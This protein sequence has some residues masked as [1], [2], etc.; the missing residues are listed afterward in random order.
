MYP[1]CTIFPSEVSLRETGAKTAPPL[2]VGFSSEVSLRET[3]AKPAPPLF[4]GFS[5]DTFRLGNSNP[6][7]FFNQKFAVFE[8]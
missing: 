3:G 5:A 6:A 1:I 2:F 7:D 8:F 4:V